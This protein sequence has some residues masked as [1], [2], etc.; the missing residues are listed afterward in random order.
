M[1]EVENVE[2]LERIVADQRQ[3][4]ADITGRPAM[5]TP[6][7]WT[8]YKEVQGY[9]ER[10]M[11]V[12]DD[13]TLLWSDDNWGNLRRLPTPEERHRTGGAGIYY[14]LDYVGGPRNYKWLN[15]TPITKIWEQMNLAWNYGAREIWVV[16]VGDLKP[17]EF[18]VEFFL[19]LAWE[20]ERWPHQ[21]LDEYGRLWA[22]REFG[23]EHAAEI[24]ALIAAYT[25]F[26][27][28]RSPELLSPETYSLVN[29]Q[30]ADRI[31][32]DYNA[33]VERAVEIRA[34]LPTAYGDAFFQLVYWPIRACANLN[35]M[36]VSA[37]RN[38]LYGEQGR[39][40]TNAL[41]ERVRALFA[42]DAELTRQYNED[43]AGGKWNH[44][45]DQVHIGY[46]YWQQPP[47][48]TMPAIVEVQPSREA[49]L[50]V[51]VEGKRQSWGPGND[52]PGV[53]ELPVIDVY[54]RQTRVVEIFNRGLEPFSFVTEA[55]Q[56]WLRVEPSAGVVDLQTSL[57]V[58]V[59]WHTVPPGTHRETL[60]IEGEQGSRI[61][62]QV[63]V[64]FPASP[65][66]GEFHGFVETDGHI[67]IEAEHFCRKVENRGITWEV[68]GDFGRTL[69]GVTPFPV[70]AASQSP[71]SDAPRL[72]YD[73]YLFT[74]GDVAVELVT[75]PT[76]DFVPG[77]GLRLAVS[78]DD[79][80]PE[81]IQIH[82]NPSRVG[83]WERTVAKSARA[84]L[85]RHRIETPGRH[86]LKIWMIDPGVVLEK[87]VVDS[88]GLRPSYLG[89]PE[90]SHDASRGPGHGTVSGV[91]NEAREKAPGGNSLF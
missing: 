53:A 18:P 36:Y 12:P 89:P 84:T 43:V 28:R 15:I 78:F 67:S 34:S 86:V 27:R 90:T 40:A 42:L 33:L 1:S 24:A 30:E 56:P 75:A 57:S 50:A 48:Q 31:V 70:T 64:S 3:I 91:Q 55:S 52:G 82:S 79:G 49:A 2:L 47:R 38:R 17:M 4:I 45:A 46:T 5:E 9:Y 63:P 58:T 20:P 73:L 83:D 71:G 29:Y 59:D 66:V 87:I 77:R 11:R 44:F 69:S 39:A 54:E 85:S 6:Q 72:E 60:V 16:N 76:L 65:A 81:V 22:E 14:H 32:A 74:V 61:L 19:N 10:G 7:V 26:N 68:L 80:E 8:L 88:G 23:P 51:A 25:K 13:V 62:V 37:G 41:A 21:R 35:E